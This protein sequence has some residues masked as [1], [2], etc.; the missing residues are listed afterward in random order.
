MEE[1]VIKTNKESYVTGII[2]AVIGGAI[3]AIPWVLA[4]VYG[5]MM[6]SILAALIAAGEF[7]GY[8]LAKGKMNKSL[9]VIIMILAI[10]IVTIATLLVIP[11]L[12]MQK[13]G[14]KVTLLNL[15]ILYLN[16][17]FS[18]AI[19]KDYVISV[20]FTILGASIITSNV[21]NQLENNDGKDI[22]LNL[23]N[24]DE[25]IKRK[26]DAIEVVKPTFMKYDAT[27]E[28]NAMMKEEVL[29][30]IE[31]PK[32]KQSFNYLMQLGIIKKNKGKFYYL[33]ANEDKQNKPHNTSIIIKTIIIVAIV[34]GVLIGVTMMLSNSKTSNNLYED[35]NVSFEIG[36][37]W[38]ETEADYSTEWNFYKYINT[39]PTSDSTNVLSEEDYASYPAIINVFYDTTSVEEIE[40]IEDIKTNLNKNLES[41]EEKPDTLD[42]NISK[43]SKNYDLLKV[44]IIYNSDP[45]QVL[46]YYYVLDEDKL[47][48]VTA[49]SF[50][51]DDDKTIEK[52]ADKLVDSFKWVK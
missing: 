49:Y 3:G 2:G 18:A 21:K 5:G 29:A 17:E 7:Y 31:N 15:E 51:L 41:L 19:M 42:M 23:N 32:A 34:L 9:P 22:K 24:K 27:N 33:E 14:I 39:L 8:K 38:L 25:L 52:E 37:D 40:S 12:L 20:I 36:E 6:L 48:C 43:T 28:H 1:N 10:I 35:T 44:K 11:A 46:Y 47:L 13:E 4:Y 30:E 26:K 45:E 16:S 50:N